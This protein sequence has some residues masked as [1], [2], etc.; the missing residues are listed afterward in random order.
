M[1]RLFPWSLFK[2]YTGWFLFQG[3]EDVRGCTS[4]A[5]GRDY[6]L[7]LSEAL[8]VSRDMEHGAPWWHSGLRTRCYH[9]SSLGHC[10]S[11]GLISQAAGT[12]KKKKKKKSG[13]WALTWNELHFWPSGKVS[14]LLCHPPTPPLPPWGT[15]LCLF[16]GHLFERIL[17]TQKVPRLGS[18]T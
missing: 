9:C 14:H 18:S 4:W 13:G 11:S 5:K 8:S 17:E 7:S 6:I 15:A 10:S 3:L 1:A 16:S 2:Q 12:A